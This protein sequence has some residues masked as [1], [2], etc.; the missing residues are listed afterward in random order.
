MA[1][2]DKE[3]AR[4]CQRRYYERNRELYFRKNKRKK[5]Q[6]RSVAQDCK[7]R[8]CDDCGCVYPYYV[9]DFDHREG[10]IKTA[11]VSRLVG[12]LNLKRLL[13]EIAK[14]DVVCANCHRIRTFK[15]EQRFFG[16]V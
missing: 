5:E 16:I 11:H 3:K 13:D 2:K 8:P 12:M 4:A 10:E 9:M 15:R 1:Y 7:S 6:L 14:C